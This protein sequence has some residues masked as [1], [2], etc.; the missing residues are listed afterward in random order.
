MHKYGQIV[1]TS[2]SVLVTTYET[3]VYGDPFFSIDFFIFILIAWSVGYQYDKVRFYE[4]K[5]KESE[6]SYKR[7]IDSLPES[8]IIHQEFKVV[9]VNDTFAKMVGATDKEEVIGKNILD[10]SFPEYKDRL[11]E[12]M[13][14]LKKEKQPL[15]ISEYK[16]KRLDGTT[17]YFEASSM[18]I[19]FGGAE[20]ILS[21]G[22][23]VTDRKEQIEQ[24]LQKSEKLAL[25]GQMAAGIAHEIRNPLTS[26]KG[27]IQLFKSSNPEKPYFDIVL[28]ELDRINSIVGEFLFLAK[29]TASVYV[30]QDIKELI[31]DVVTLINNQS[32]LNNVQI[33]VHSTMNLPLISCEKNQLKQVL[34]STKKWNGSYANGRRHPNSNTRK[35]GRTNFHSLHRPGYRDSKRTTFYIRRTLLYNKG[36][37]N[38]SWI[39]DLL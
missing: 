37:G 22:K 30:E 28:S 38:R 5:T 10:Y 21:I 31:N 12:R 11:N 24:M 29:P 14:L 36:K 35:R 32:I 27:F 26:I 6:E 15:S 19:N 13:K 17:F 33:S 9:Y 7:L 18:S 16:F 1:L 2:V 34:K 25:L 8:I 4:R 3:F 20:A 39:N 23:D